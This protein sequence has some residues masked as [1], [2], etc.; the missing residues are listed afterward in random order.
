MK[1]LAFFLI[2]LIAGIFAF[3]LAMKTVGWERVIEA[4]KLFLSL[5]GLLIVF[6]TVL[7]SF[8]GYWR[9][10]IILE[11]LSGR[12]DFKNLK[13]LWFAGFTVSYFTSIS[14]VVGDLFKSYFVKK[15]YD[16][17]WQK[18]IASSII[19]RLLDSTVFFVSTI[20]GIF[21]FLFY[22]RVLPEK[23]LLFSFIGIIVLLVLLL[24]FYFKSLKKESTI[25][26]FLNIFGMKR[27]KIEESEKGKMIFETEREIIKNISIKSRIFWEGIGL[28]VL[29]YFLHF[30]RAAVLVL[31]LQDGAS[32]GKMFAIFGINNIASLSPTPAVLGALEATGI[33]SFGGVG[34]G[35]AA[36]TVFAMV[37]RSSDVVIALI[38]GFCLVKIGI[39]LTTKKILEFFGKEKN[40]ED[41]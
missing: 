36:G 18:S 37:I 5:K 20:L 41:E 17:N 27:K 14:F 35:I 12:K 39:H 32:L 30:L 26:W 4:L 19:D 3:V 8:A 9:W 13:E 2:T 38:G 15:N 16:L 28:T 31:F 33:L 29:K 1:K 25:E 22:S 7:L 40:N 34:F 24:F 6:I 10:K 23:I 11:K 21:A